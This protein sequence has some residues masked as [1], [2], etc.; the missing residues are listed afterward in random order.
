MPEIGDYVIDAGACMGDTALIFSNTVGSTGKVF[1]FDPVAEHLEILNYNIK[2]FPHNNVIAIPYGL[3]NRE[4][5]CQPLVINSYNPGFRLDNQNIPLCSIDAFVRTH[6]VD[7]VDFI[8]MDIEGSELDAL[9]GAQE[10]IRK[11]KPKL[12]ISLYHKP[13]DIFELV[14]HI[15]NKFSFYKIYIDHYTIHQEEMIMYCST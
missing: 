10:S 11:F 14:K 9:L 12:A 6:N 15:K 1:A 2:N 13:N 5:S 7:K 4:V 3:S 8:K